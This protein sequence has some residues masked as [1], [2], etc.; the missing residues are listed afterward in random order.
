M[1]ESAL[2]LNATMSICEER[3]LKYGQPGTKAIL[4]QLKFSL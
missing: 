1:S 3:V 4:K 2:A